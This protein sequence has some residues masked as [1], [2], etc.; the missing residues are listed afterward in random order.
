MTSESKSAIDVDG[1]LFNLKRLQVGTKVQIEAIYDLLFA[2]D[3]ADNS[4]S[5]REMQHI[6]DL[7]PASCNNYGLTIFTNKTEVPRQTTPKAVQNEPFITINGPKLKSMERFVYLGS[8][9]SNTFCIDDV[10]NM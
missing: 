8:T 4:N 9:L 6:V 5:E 10:V 2:D 3:C 7:F 1:D